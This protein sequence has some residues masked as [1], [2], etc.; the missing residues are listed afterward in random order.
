MDLRLH[1]KAVAGKTPG[2]G[3]RLFRRF[4]D[5]SPGYRHSGGRKKIPSLVFV[6]VHKEEKLMVGRVGE[7]AF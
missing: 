7:S 3:F 1:D 5:G 2:N 4:G 6:N